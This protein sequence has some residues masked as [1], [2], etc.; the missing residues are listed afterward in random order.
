[1]II[2]SLIIDTQVAQPL[3]LTDSNLYFVTF[4]LFDL[5]EK[6]EAYILLL[7]FYT[8]FYLSLNIFKRESWL[9]L[10]CPSQTCLYCLSCISN[11][12]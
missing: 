7:K 5:C 4:C 12:I 9:A 6:L 10:N 1:M 11:L 8:M 3:V 2:L